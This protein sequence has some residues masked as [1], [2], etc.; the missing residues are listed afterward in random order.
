M[1]LPKIDT[2][3]LGSALLVWKLK[4]NKNMTSIKV[5]KLPTDWTALEFLNHHLHSGLKSPCV[6]LFVG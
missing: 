2:V 5:K 4:N 3:D 6:Y 1:K